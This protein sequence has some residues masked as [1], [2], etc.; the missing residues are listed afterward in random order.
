MRIILVGLGALGQ[1]LLGH[2]A[3]QEQRL[4]DQYGLRVKIVAA[5]DTSGA[6]VHPSGIDPTTLLKAKRSSTGLASLQPHFRPRRLA[7]FQ[8]VQAHTIALRHVQDQ[9]EIVKPDH[10]VQT[11]GQV[12][13]QSGNFAVQRD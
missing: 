1:G 8:Y 3:S 13:K 6:V 10:P 5:L 12:M 2:L 11:P 7:G 9:V 4:L